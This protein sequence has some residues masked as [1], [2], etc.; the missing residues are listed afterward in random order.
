VKQNLNIY[1]TSVNTFQG[2]LN[3]LAEMNP[4]SQQYLRKGGH[5]S[6]VC[7]I[8]PSACLVARLSYNLTIQILNNHLS[9]DVPVMVSFIFLSTVHTCLQNKVQPI[10]HYAVF[11]GCLWKCNEHHCK[12]NSCFHASPS[13][14]KGTDSFPQICSIS[15]SL[16]Q[17][18]T[19]M[20]LC[21]EN[22]KNTAL[23]HPLQQ[24][25]HSHRP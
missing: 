5:S 23:L 25:V 6:E 14:H 12:L 17:A 18:V 21:S 16:H 9:T 11:L 8:F 10:F 15:L 4:I 3:Q 19:E 2:W 7:L 13:G 22:A 1:W 20:K 24:T